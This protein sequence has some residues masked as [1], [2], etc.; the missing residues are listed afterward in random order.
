MIFQSIPPHV[1]LNLSD[2]GLFDNKNRQQRLEILKAIPVNQFDDKS[3]FIFSNN[4]WSDYQRALGTLSFL[5]YKNIRPFSV[6][7]NIGQFLEPN[8][9]KVVDSINSNEQLIRESRQGNK[10]N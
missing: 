4:G 10:L 6:L 5:S 3:R 8:N 9:E 7:S 2:N 1:S